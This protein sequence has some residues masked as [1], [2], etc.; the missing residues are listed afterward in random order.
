MALQMPDPV[1]PDAP[2]L[3]PTGTLEQ[4]EERLAAAGALGI[5]VAS[6]SEY[7]G[8]TV[9]G[10]D[11][12]QPISPAAAAVMRAAL[13]KYKVMAFKEQFLTHDQHVAVRSNSP[14]FRS[15]ACSACHRWSDPCASPTCSASQGPVLLLRAPCSGP[16]PTADGTCSMCG[17]RRRRSAR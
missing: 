3:F 10:L 6:T 2:W 9:V 12:S 14:M 8:C 4:V 17:R 13:L 1:D 7:I 15:S 11:L 5:T 16:Q